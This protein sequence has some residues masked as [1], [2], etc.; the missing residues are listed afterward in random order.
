MCSPALQAD[1]ALIPLSVENNDRHFA[2]LRQ[3]AGERFLIVL[4]PSTEASSVRINGI[5]PGNLSSQICH[6]AQAYVD[7]DGIQVKL[8]GVSYGIFKL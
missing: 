5:R 1:G 3:A 8:A 4:N 7:R 6:G 2:Y